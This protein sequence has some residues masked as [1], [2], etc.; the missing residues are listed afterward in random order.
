MKNLTL[1]L[2]LFI[3]SFS[4]FAIANEEQDA[5]LNGSAA[6]TEAKQTEEA[7]SNVR[8]GQPFVGTIE[9]EKRARRDW[10]WESEIE[11]E[12]T[13]WALYLDNDL[14][15]LR[16]GD[17]DYTGGMSL[18]LSG[19]RAK[20]YWFSL[21]PVLE[22]LDDWSSV[23][24]LHDSGDRELHSIETGFTV[25]TPAN[26]NQ[27]DMQQ[28]DRPYASLIYLSNTK[29][30]IDLDNDSAWVSSF[31]VGILGSSI[32]EE[33][34]TEIHKATGSEEPV[35]WENQISDGGE[36]TFRYSLAKQNLFHFNYQGDNRVEVSTTSQ[37]SLGYLTE[38]SFGMAAR[39]GE[40][41]TPWYSFRPQFNDYSEKSSSMAGSEKGSEE[42]YFW[43][44][45]N[46]HARLYNSFLQGQFK[47][48]ESA[49]S[50]NEVRHLVADGWLGVTKQ[51]KSGWRV[52]YLLR[53]QTSEI[54]SGVAD[55]STVWGGFIVSKGW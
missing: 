50:A 23:S 30:S 33:I 18:T 26:I 21:N 19:S 49:Y 44:G 39:V 15:A 2:S 8:P 20:D 42:L 31:T 22:K 28:G 48:T 53:G 51:F 13:G 5:G 1:I 27:V 9:S 12:D 55:R 54:K 32:V 47:H 25:F 24:N 6:N 14:F 40:F 10:I 38:V 37:A 17:R 4:S 52:S 46:L 43:A 34:Q 45:F 3:F 35:G 29:E 16:D 41:N 36:L 7:L 11:P